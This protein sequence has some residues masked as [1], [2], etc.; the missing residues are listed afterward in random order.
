MLT[1]G[2]A[3][4]RSPESVNLNMTTRPDVHH[5]QSGYHET[6]SNSC[7]QYTLDMI[8]HNLI[9]P[10][11]SEGQCF[12][13]DTLLQSVSDDSFTQGTQYCG[14]LESQKR[15]TMSGKRKR[16]HDSLCDYDSQKRLRNNVQSHYSN[17]YPQGV[18]K[19]DGRR[20]MVPKRISAIKR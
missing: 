1:D 12:T 16:S 7:S 15:G 5:L 3:W 6:S 17:L 4:E 14:Y 11:V 19:I 2:L 8:F 10:D 9:H 13:F 20:L 18:A